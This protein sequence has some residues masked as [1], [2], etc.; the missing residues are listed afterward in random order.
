MLLARCKKGAVTSNRY[1]KGFRKTG[2]SDMKWITSVRHCIWNQTSLL[3]SGCKGLWTGTQRPNS[4]TDHT[5][6]S[7][8]RVIILGALPPLLH[9]RYLRKRTA[10]TTEDCKKPWF[11]I[12]SSY[13]SQIRYGHLSH[14]SAPLL[15]TSLVSLLQVSVQMLQHSAGRQHRE[16]T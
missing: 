9:T 8:Q 7:S 4:D 3:Y 6:P 13:G 14:I 16:L 10:F 2:C 5:P 1:N 12:S 15:V 11:N